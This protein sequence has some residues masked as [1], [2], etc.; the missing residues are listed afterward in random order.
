MCFYV[1]TV[2]FSGG[3]VKCA[4]VAE[5]LGVTKAVFLPGK[6]DEGKECKDGE[7]VNKGIL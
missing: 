2:L 3:R 1:V 4:G 5:E 6:Y 7:S